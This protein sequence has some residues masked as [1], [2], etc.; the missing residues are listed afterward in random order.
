MITK[1]KDNEIVVFGSNLAGRHGRGAAKQALGFG[2]RWG[3][4]TGLQ[5]KS[6]GIPTKDANI[7]RVLTVAEIKP[8]VE[9]FITF[10]Q[11]NP[12]LTFLVTEIGCGLAGYMP[13]N[14]APLFKRALT[15]NN[16]KLPE[17]F[18]KKLINLE[19]E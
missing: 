18:I 7:R 13:K 3:Q 10:A 12:H 5:G 14:I 4:A 9:D 15:I 16:I 17:R 6:Y 2:A 19:Y 8:Y 11:A 1:L